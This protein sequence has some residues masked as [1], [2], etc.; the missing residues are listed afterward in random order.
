MLRFTEDQM[1]LLQ[2]GTFMRLLERRISEHEE[3]VVRLDD[4]V[5]THLWE[6][7]ESLRPF[8]ID[9]IRG[10]LVVCHI[11]WELGPDILERLPPFATVL[12]DPAAGEAEKVN[13][14]WAMRTQLLSTLLEG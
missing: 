13:A 8:R 2:R 1:E 7:A 3:Q 5:R 12:R 6:L 10:C 14:L 11:C 4:Q 9:S